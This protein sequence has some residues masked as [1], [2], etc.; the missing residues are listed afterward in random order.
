[1]AEQGELS[2]KG[3]FR[4]NDDGVALGG[5]A[6]VHNLD[7]LSSLFERGQEAS[8]LRPQTAAQ[9]VGRAFAA[10]DRIEFAEKLFVAHLR[11]AAAPQAV[12]HSGQSLAS[13]NPQLLNTHPP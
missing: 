13:A 7:N 2:R 10:P 11:R 3:G 9:R 1:M 12:A 5:E 8:V 6:L 4:S